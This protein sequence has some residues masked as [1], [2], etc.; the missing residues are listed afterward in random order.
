MYV[1]LSVSDQEK[2]QFQ[3]ETSFH[4][5]QSQSERHHNVQ[6]RCIMCISCFE[7]PRRSWGVVSK[8]I[9]TLWG[10]SSVETFTWNRFLGWTRRHMKSKSFAASNLDHDRPMFN[11]RFH[12]T[13]SAYPKR[14]QEILEECP[15]EQGI[16]R[17]SSDTWIRGHFPR[18]SYSRDRRDWNVLLFRIEAK[19]DVSEN[20]RDPVSSWVLGQLD[21]SIPP[22][23]PSYRVYVH[24]EKLQ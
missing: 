6:E 3:T 12:I 10:Q 7:Y 19:M 24:S 4:S 1:F 15:Q 17:P 5:S 18:E 13:S 23:W 21:R 11:Q 14:F 22:P 8:V 20:T 2:R 9:V 16:H